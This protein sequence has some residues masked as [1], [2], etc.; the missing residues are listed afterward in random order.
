MNKMQSNNGTGTE[1]M[2]PNMVAKTSSHV[3]MN[4]MYQA[5]SDP[6][7]ITGVG[8]IWQSALNKNDI[9]KRPN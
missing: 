3:G 7:H 6:K 2:T 4:F 1:I 5:P 8:T 9:P